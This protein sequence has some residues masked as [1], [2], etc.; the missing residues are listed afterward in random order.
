V[1]PLWRTVAQVFPTFEDRVQTMLSNH[2]R[3]APSSSNCIRAAHQALHLPFTKHYIFFQP[4]N[5]PYD[6]TP[7]LPIPTL[8]RWV[9]L[10]KSHRAQPFEQAIQPQRPSSTDSLS[11]P[12]AVEA[13]RRS[14]ASASTSA[15]LSSTEHTEPAQGRYPH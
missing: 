9:Q 6:L 2:E 1:L 13:E 10:K 8:F 14:S 4:L 7:P 15:P 12:S 5:D 11:S 3:C